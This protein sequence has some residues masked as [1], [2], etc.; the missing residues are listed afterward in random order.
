MCGDSTTTGDVEK[1]MNGV[2][3]DLLVTDPPYNVNYEGKAGKL[4]NDNMDN[5]SFKQFLRDAFTAADGVMKSGATFYIWH[6][7]SE[8]YN[9]R[10][11]CYDVG[12]KVRQCLIWVKN[13]IVLGRQDYQW[14]HEPCL[15]GWKEGTH[16]WDGGRKERTALTSFDIFELRDKSKTELLKFIEDY[17]CNKEDYETT[18]IYEEK[19]NRNAEH[20]TM[21]PIKLLARGIKN[22]S[23]ENNT[24]LDL[25]G[26]SGSTL[27]ACEQLNRNCCMMELDP[28]YV[29]VIIA[30]WE[31]F[32]GQKAVRL[33]NE[34]G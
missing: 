3:A 29:D 31:Q 4:E 15:Y 22:S 17:C 1:L 20:P 6:A 30:R 13:S 19:P 11:A 26:G 27:I 32:T 7:D 21:K 25:F 18:I 5:D 14:K 24:V 33:N 2:K 23:K 34:Q 8:G 28:H 10:G 16:Y 9:F 12:W